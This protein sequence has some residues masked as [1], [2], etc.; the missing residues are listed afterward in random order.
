MVALAHASY[1]R[2]DLD[3]DAGPFMAE[4]GGEQ[5]LGFG[6]REGV[7]VG[8]ADAGGL[9]LDQHLAVAGAFE[10]DLRQLDRLSSG[11]GDGGA[12]LHGRPPR[13]GRSIKAENRR[14]AKAGPNEAPNGADYTLPRGIHTTSVCTC[15]G[16][17]PARPA[18]PLE[19]F[20]FDATWGEPAGSDLGRSEIDAAFI[21]GEEGRRLGFARQSRRHEIRMVKK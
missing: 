11:E 13:L 8:V 18:E 6:A 10:I 19:H 9:D 20:Q 15:P 4:D 16:R 3:D 1:A 14:S 12:G 21:G 2:A 17:R 7:I 5:A